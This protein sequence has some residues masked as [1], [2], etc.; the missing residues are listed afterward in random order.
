M[1]LESSFRLRSARRVFQTPPSVVRRWE[2][3]TTVD[4]S[5]E[6]PGLLREL[7]G[8]PLEIVGAGAGIHDC[9]ERALFSKDQL[10]ISSQTILVRSV[11]QGKGNRADDIGTSRDRSESGCR[12]SQQMSPRL[13]LQSLPTSAANDVDPRF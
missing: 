12:A 5:I 8:Q 2:S 4:F 6:I 1:R 11:S 7:L 9:L 13:S 3:T 10:D